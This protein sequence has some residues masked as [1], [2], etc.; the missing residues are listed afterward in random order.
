MLARNFNKFMNHSGGR[1]QYDC[2]EGGRGSSRRREGLKCYECEGVGHMK[3]NCH[4]AQRRDIKGYECKGVGHTRREC[5]NSKNRKGVSLQSSDDS[6]SEKDEKVMKNL[7][8]FGAHKDGSSESSDSDVGTDDEEYHV[9]LK[10]WLRVKDQN[11]RLEDVAQKQNELL[12]ELSE[13]LVAVNDKN[14]EVTTRERERAKILERDL[15][16]NHKQIRMLNSGSKNLDKI[17]SMGQPAKVTCGLGYRGAGEVLQ[18]VAVSNKPKV[19]HQCSNMKAIH[20]FL[21]HRCAA[22][23]QKNTDR[24]ISNC[25]RPNKKQ[26]RMCCWFY[27]KVGHKKVECFAREKRRNMAKKVNKTFTKPK[28]VE[29]VFLVKSGLLDEIKEKTSEE[30]CNSVRSDLEVAQEASSPEPEHRVVCGTKGKEI[31]VHQEVMRGDLQEGDSEI[32]PRQ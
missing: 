28:R 20:E 7:V 5:P 32:T 27:Q 21:K 16:D 8:A 14:E 13:E 23:T 24:C 26:H 4:V 1:N 29:E 3:A 6:E 22:G 18:R 2:E 9:M 31:K 30:G 15:T 10:K 17:L 25:V 11:L 12:E 19:V